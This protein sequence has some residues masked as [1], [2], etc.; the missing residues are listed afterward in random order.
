MGEQGLMAAVY[1]IEIADG[2]HA[3]LALQGRRI[4]SENLH[5]RRRKTLNYKGFAAAFAGVDARI[6]SVKRL[7]VLISGRGTNMAAIADA[8]RARGWAARIEAVIAARPD[9]PGLDDALQ[10]GLE[11]AVVDHLDH[12]DRESYD[13][14][15]ADRIDAYSPDLILL[16]GFMRILGDRFVQRFDGRL[17]NIHPSLLPSFPGLH[18]HR[19]ALEAGVRVHGATVHWVTQSLDHGP[20]IAQAAVPV[21]TDDDEA[22]L[23]ARVLRLEHRLYPLA[24][25]WLIQG[26]VSVTDGQVAVQGIDGRARLLFDETP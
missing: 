9:A 13:A 4:A 2:E 14:A 16:A 24:V 8:C 19:R 22:R 20:I 11:T 5:A 17:I 10:R 15:L 23:A 12:P 25:E 7:V 26:R 21:L 18:T 6:R 1:P 3:R